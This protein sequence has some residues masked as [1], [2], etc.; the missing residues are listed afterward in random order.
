MIKKDETKG[1]LAKQH[2]VFV[3]FFCFFRFLVCCVIGGTE[4]RFLP[5]RA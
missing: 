5:A 2:G 3:F 1:T 4:A